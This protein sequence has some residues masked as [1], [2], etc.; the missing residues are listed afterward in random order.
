MKK[1]TFFT[2]ILA[3]AMA[4]SS[5]AHAKN[6]YIE[7]LKG[8][9]SPSSI[10]WMLKNQDECE[11]I[12]FKS[13][14]VTSPVTIEMQTG[15]PLLGDA[16]LIGPT[17]S[18][19]T[20]L[21][22]LKPASSYSDEQLVYLGD[23][24]TDATNPTIENFYIALGEAKTAKVAVDVDG[25]DHIIKNVRIT[26]AGMNS[27]TKPSGSVGVRINA[28]STILKDVRVAGYEMGAQVSGSNSQFLVTNGAT[29]SFHH[30]KTGIVIAAGHDN[31]ISQVVF[32]DNTNLAI[33]LVGSANDSILNP[34]AFR[35]IVNPTDEKVSAI[36][37]LVD[38]TTAKIQVYSA[39]AATIDKAQGQG[40]VFAKGYEGLTKKSWTVKERNRFVK[41]ITA[42][43]LSSTGKYAVTAF[44]STNAAA[45]STSEFSAAADFT[46]IPGRIKAGAECLNKDWFLKSIDGIDR[47][48]TAAATAPSDPWGFDY[49]GDGCTNY[50]ENPSMDCVTFTSKVDPT[51]PAKKDCSGTNPTEPTSGFYFPNT[52]IPVEPI[53]YPCRNGACVFQ[54]DILNVDLDADDDG[55]N[56]L[57]DNC[58]YIYNPDQEN[59]DG[60]PL[61]DACDPDIDNDGLTN[62]IEERAGSGYKSDDPD[63]D[64]DG[65]CD[66]PSWGIFASGRECIAPSDNCPLVANPDQADSDFDGIGDACDLAPNDKCA[67]VDSDGDGYSDVIDKCPRVPDDQ[68]DSDN[69]GVSD[70]CDFYDNTFG[71]EYVAGNTMSSIA[72]DIDGDWLIDSADGDI[73]GDGIPN[74]QEAAG[75]ESIWSPKPIKPDLMYDIDGDGIPNVCDDNDDGDELTD[76]EESSNFML[77]WYDK[78]NPDIKGEKV[79]EKMMPAG[80]CIDTDKDTITDGFDNCPGVTE[81]NVRSCSL[82]GPESTAPAGTENACWNVSQSDADGDD[83]GD[84]C[85]NC[86][87]VAN[88]DQKDLDNDGVG[89]ICDDD[90]D[91]DGILNQYDNC[92]FIYNPN[93]EDED[94]D[95][96]G[97]VCD[98]NTSTGGGGGGGTTDPI[99]TGGVEISGSGSSWSSTGGCSN[100]SGATNSDLTGIIMLT[101][102]SLPAVLF[103]VRRKF[104]K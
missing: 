6:C 98:P 70:A 5:A 92:V 47:N 55:I 17:K 80:V 1:L 65:F 23:A 4:F 75:C 73:D 14:L 22:T 40:K 104:A 57:D 89:D 74:G 13:G 76:A 44:N 41:K 50:Q 63:S 28:D 29:S 102:S 11:A 45:S 82:R 77:K 81:E 48:G 12:Y 54:H 35:A 100:V 71:V 84:I 93:Q 53:D 33:D 10:V 62:E 20:P 67:A 27:Q 37:G 38:K 96:I 87:N 25:N 30:N 51:D 95:G 52:M 88:I 68:R 34:V 72:N 101:L 26:T 56:N 61:G 15:I 21:V 66:G 8:Y 9:D 64:G 99:P 90:V 31:Y 42:G 2:L 24:R 36:T 19:G 7:N 78:Q 69:D 79:A 49:D 97:N 103:S 85:D 59:T 58:V 3:S 43:E 46:K 94:N 91:G 32:N 83:I 60:D 86:V 16:R 18:D 39:D